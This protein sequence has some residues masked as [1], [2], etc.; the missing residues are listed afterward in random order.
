LFAATGDHRFEQRMRQA[1][2]SGFN[3][4]SHFEIFPTLLVAMGYDESWV[5]KAYG[6][7]LLDGPAEGP[8]VFMVGNPYL[9]PEL[10]VADPH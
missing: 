3:R 2:Q 10:I 4:M 5:K 7:S 6:P 9:N 8:R 1:A